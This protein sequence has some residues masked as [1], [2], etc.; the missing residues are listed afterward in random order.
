MRR[1]CKLAAVL[2]KDIVG[3]AVP[4][5]V[6]PAALGDVQHAGKTGRGGKAL[7]VTERDF[8]RAV[9]THRKPG[10]K[11]VLRLARDTDPAG[12]QPG[13]FLGQVGI[14]LPAVFHVGIE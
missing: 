12:Q 4:G 5:G 2:A 1:A 13:Q 6:V 9:S 14:I 3:R 8:I 10:N 11:G 7:R